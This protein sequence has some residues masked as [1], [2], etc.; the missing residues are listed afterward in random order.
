MLLRME[1]WSYPSFCSFFLIVQRVSGNFEKDFDLK[2][3]NW[4]SYVFQNRS[5]RFK[6][7]QGHCQTRRDCVETPSNK[8][9]RVCFGRPN[10]QGVSAHT[11]NRQQS[12]QVNIKKHQNGVPVTNMISTTAACSPC[13]HREKVSCSLTLTSTQPHQ[14]RIE[15]SNTWTPCIRVTTTTNLTTAKLAMMTSRKSPLI[16]T[17]SLL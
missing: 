12:K 1:E 2:M 13:R 15:P 7:T 6:G 8:K 4:K 11:P 17:S 9:V 14:E 3:V 5:P 10:I 16:F